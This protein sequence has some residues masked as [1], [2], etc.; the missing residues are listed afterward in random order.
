MQERETLPGNYD[1]P[2][3]LF[4]R[5]SASQRAYW[6]A[7]ADSWVDREE[8]R[9]EREREEVL[10]QVAWLQGIFGPEFDWSTIPDGGE[11]GEGRERGYSG[12]MMYDLY[13]DS[14]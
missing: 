8:A 2:G 13:D 4:Q 5:A 9:E 10:D 6:R 3:K 11:E 1:A 7:R 14:D 12:P